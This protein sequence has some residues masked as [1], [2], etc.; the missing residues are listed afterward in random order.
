MFNHLALDT[1]IYYFN[2]RERIRQKKVNN[3]PKPWTDDPVLREFS[4][5]NILRRHDKTSRYLIEN[6]YYPNFH[7]SFEEALFNAMAFRYFGSI[8]YARHLGWTFS[9][10]L[11]DEYHLRRKL[12]DAVED[13]RTNKEKPFTSAY[14]VT[15]A[16]LSKPKEEVVIDH[17]ILPF[18]SYFPTLRKIWE[19]DLKPARWRPLAEFMIRNVSGCGAFMAKEILQDVSYTHILDNYKDR[20]TWTPM[21]PGA[22]RG[23]NRILG[24]PLTSS[25]GK[26]LEPVKELR[27]IL[28][29]NAEPHMEEIIPEF[30]LH[31]VQFLLCEVDK[32]MR[33]RN[34]EGRPKRRYPGGR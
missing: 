32:L 8:A 29:D 18:L 16:G 14:V 23:M 12:F 30:D 25:K 6:Y 21:G 27:Q 2:E 20:N 3:E 33:S 15:N 11:K 1:A 7:C 28:L 5:T 19:Q 17:F 26:S 4:F 24:E 9:D 13:T 31:A 22:I 34:K 10:E